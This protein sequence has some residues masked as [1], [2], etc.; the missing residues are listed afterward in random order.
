MTRGDGTDL[1]CTV[2]PVV[3]HRGCSFKVCG[4]HW[5]ARDRGALGLNA[6]PAEYRVCPRCMKLWSFEDPAEW[7]MAFDGTWR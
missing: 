6:L 5:D 1:C 4:E 7:E 2:N 3:R